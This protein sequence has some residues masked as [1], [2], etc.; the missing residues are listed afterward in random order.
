V[1]IGIASG[2]WTATHWSGL[3]PAG[4]PPQFVAMMPIFMAVGVAISLVVDL[5]LWFF[6]AR[7]AAEIAKWIF[8]ILFAVAL[9]GM[10]RTLFGQQQHVVL[11]TVTLAV[12]VVRLLLNGFCTALLLRPDAKRWFRGERGPS[13]LHD[14]FS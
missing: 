7:K 8:V 5:L 13:A 14:T 11:P 2:I 1:I 9:A 4:T 10:A 12:S 6:I 3:M